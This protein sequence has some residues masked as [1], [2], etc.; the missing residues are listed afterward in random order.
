MNDDGTVNTDLL[1]AYAT[2]NRATLEKWLGKEDVCRLFSP[3]THRVLDT[4]FKLYP[5]V[6]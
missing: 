6:F 3:G 4:S 1:F 5:G 2:K